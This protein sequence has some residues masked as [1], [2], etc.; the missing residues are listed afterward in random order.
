MGTYR[1][2]HIYRIRF[3]RTGKIRFLSHLEQIETIRRAIR[4]AE[5]PVNY[6]SGFHPQMEIS[7][8]PAISVGY[9]SLCEFADIELEK[10]IE[11][12]EIFKSIEKSLPHGFSV[13][14]VKKIPGFLPSI[15]SVVNLAEYSIENIEKFFSEEQ[16]KKIIEDTLSKN[17]I[18]FEFFKKNKSEKLDLRKL[19]YKLEYSNGILSLFLRFRPGK[20]IK[21]E[22]VI[23]H[24]FNLDENSVKY[25]KVC[26]KMLYF[27]KPDGTLTSFWVRNL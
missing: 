23:G 3:S 16:V 20:N 1:K 11:P 18:L 17:E 12:I 15:D 6:S 5:L 22:I 4:R 26:R 14:E 2:K 27:E 8:G 13:L 24:I 7:F 9:E 10:F 25:L 21:P 19:I